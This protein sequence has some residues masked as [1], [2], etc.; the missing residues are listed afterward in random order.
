MD[1]FFAVFNSLSHVIFSPINRE[2][3][4]GLIVSII[5]GIPVGF[6]ALIIF[7]FYIVIPVIKSVL[8]ILFALLLHLIIFAYIRM[9]YKKIFI[10]FFLKITVR[11][12]DH[13]KRI[14]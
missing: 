9:N 8:S 4:P 11:F 7:Y 10:K 5:L 14:L 2:Y 6:Y 12:M 3:N 1:P 13:Y